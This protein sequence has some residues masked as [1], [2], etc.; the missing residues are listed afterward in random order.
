MR[1]RALV[2]D[3]YGEYFRYA[4]GGVRLGPLTT[5]MGVF[6]VEAATVRVVM[7]RLR[8]E[9]WFDSD[10]SG[11]EVTYRLNDKSWRLLDDGRTRIFEREPDEWDGLWTQA[12]LDESVLARDRRKR[13][14]T[15]LTW[16]GF[17]SYGG[18]VWFSP[19]DRAKRLREMCTGDDELHVQVLSSRSTGLPDDRLISQRCWDLR[20][21]GDDY[22]RF[23][24]KFQPFLSRYRRGMGGE[25]A[26]VERM[27]LIQDYRRYPFR[28]PDLPSALLPAGWRGR[29]AHEVFTEA[30][31]LLRADAEQYVVT[32]TGEELASPDM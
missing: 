12:L 28:D 4:G 24:E 19:H 7:A 31:E 32:V 29:A 3:L 10:K 20:E 15:A 8:K 11:R 16:C 27:R 9:G 23:I 1:P 21:L 18:A 5:L 14:E 6:G 2:F 25:Q 17:G 26:L 13:I 22:Q 30:H